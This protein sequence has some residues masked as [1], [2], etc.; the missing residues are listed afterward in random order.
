M[1]PTAQ[2]RIER[3]LATRFGTQIAVTPNQQGME[4]MA[5]LLE[6]CSHRRWKPDPVPPDLLKLLCACAL[7][8]PSKSDLQQADIVHVADLPLRSRIMDLIP[9]MPWMKEAPVFLVFC[10]N[11]RRQ[12]QVA[13]WRGKS[14]AND[15]LDAYM[16]ATVDAAIVMT[17]FLHAAAAA[18]LGCCAISAVRNEAGKVSEM[19][20]LPDF[21]Y[22]ICG[23]CV[24]YPVFGNRITPRLPLDVTVHTDRFD[25]TGL[26]EKIDGYDRRRH[27]LQPYSKQRSV[28]KF[29]TAGFYGWSEDKARQYAEPA[30]ADFGEFIRAKGFNLR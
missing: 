2:E 23:M 14:F 18:G 6:Q 12:R 20:G 29:G 13:E 25:E 3:A 5:T 7:A 22:P 28:K 26:A 11:N 21:V 27:A 17:A 4:C 24:G 16:N 1:E 9:D 19:L 15:H 30:R 10:A 8:A